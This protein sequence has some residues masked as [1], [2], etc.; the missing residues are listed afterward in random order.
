MWAPD[1]SSKPVDLP[2]TGAA[3][4]PA[5]VEIA[6]E[7][8]KAPV[9]IKLIGY[10]TFGDEADGQALSLTGRVHA[11]QVVA[12]TRSFQRGMNLNIDYEHKSILTR[13]A[14]SSTLAGYV[15]PSTLVAE[16]DG[17]YGA[18]EW[19]PVAAAALAA[20]EWKFVCAH[21]QA[22]KA[23]G[24][25]TR[26]IGAGLTN[27]SQIDFPEL[28]SARAAALASL[29]SEERA[30][31]SAVGVDPSDFLEQKRRGNAA[32][33]LSGKLTKEEAAICAAAGVEPVDFLETKA[34]QEGL[35]QTVGLTEEERAMCAAVGVSPA[36]FID[37]KARKNSDGR[38]A[39]MTKEEQA[40]CA[41]VGVSPA[42][43]IATRDARR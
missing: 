29:S 31:C 27:A 14:A 11:S 2:N 22:E 43:F 9:R 25:I 26:L 37:T 19:T 40:I 5:P 38:L 32:G 34:A 35:G 12:A 33:T 13:S 6:P 17:I 18:V 3:V 30:I 10:G 15:S 42:E 24:R 28:A 23:G 21:V 36:E 8:G 20:K 41:M 1:F 16:N 4:V 39:R 7:Y